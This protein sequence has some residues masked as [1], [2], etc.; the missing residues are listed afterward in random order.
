MA[1]YGIITVTPDLELEIHYIKEKRINLSD[2]RRL[3][4]NYCEAV[5]IVQPF[6]LYENFHFQSKID[7]SGKQMIIML[8][9][10]DGKCKSNKVN[11][12]ASYLYKSDEHNDYIVGTVAFV[13]CEYFEGEGVDFVG[14]EMTD[15]TLRLYTLLKQMCKSGKKIKTKRG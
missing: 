1:E 5:Q 8:V 11:H 3:I 14:L 6:R 9:D 10:E 13:A 12:A 4:K 7:D 2:V 15:E